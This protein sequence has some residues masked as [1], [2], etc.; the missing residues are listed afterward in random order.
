MGIVRDVF[1]YDRSEPLALRLAAL[2]VPL[3]DQLEELV[4]QADGTTITGARA[5]FLPSHLSTRRTADFPREPVSDAARTVRYGGDL[6]GSG[7]DAKDRRELGEMA[8]D[9]GKTRPRRIVGHNIEA[10]VLAHSAASIRSK[11]LVI[12]I[13]RAAASTYLQRSRNSKGPLVIANDPQSGFGTALRLDRRKR[14]P[15]F[16]QCL[17]LSRGLAVSHLRF[18]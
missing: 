6:L 9:D 1:G 8:A 7:H 14:G 11:R 12:N 3:V 17:D 16:S 18:R 5:K 2:G 13:S 10:D 4:V 15:E